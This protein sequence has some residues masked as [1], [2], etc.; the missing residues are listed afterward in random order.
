[1]VPQMR[2]ISAPEQGIWVGDLVDQGVL[3]FGGPAVGLGVPRN[4]SISA[5]DEFRALEQFRE[6]VQFLK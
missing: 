4:R 3:G 6:F 2:R 5:S 1:M